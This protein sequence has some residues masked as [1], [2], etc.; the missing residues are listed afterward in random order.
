MRTKKAF[1]L[2]ELLLVVA[3]MGLFFIFVTPSFLK[4]QSTSKETNITEL[5]NYLTHYALK[6]GVKNRISFVCEKGFDNC[7]IFDEKKELESG[8]SLALANKAASIFY[9]VKSDG[10]VIE[11]NY[12][13]TKVTVADKRVY[14][15]FWIDPNG[16]SD[17][18]IAYDSKKYF[19]IDAISSV[20]H[21]Y[22]TLEDAKKAYV[23]YDKMPINDSKYYFNE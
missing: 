7:K 20:V 15:E 10:E 23:K 17:S 3:L 2:F 6:N 13:G 19:V 21:E 14:F 4:S 8:I 9:D 18:V 5:K 1:T 12:D 11:K 16:Y 22:Q